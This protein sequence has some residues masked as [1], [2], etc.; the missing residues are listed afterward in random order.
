MRKEASKVM[1]HNYCS[2][3]PGGLTHVV[4]ATGI[5]LAI[6]L[7][8]TFPDGFSL[9][10]GGA[11]AAPTMVVTNGLKSAACEAQTVDTIVGKLGCAGTKEAQHRKTTTLRMGR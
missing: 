2:N 4:L 3:G 5:L 10:T 6:G 8:S 9:A 1:A 11:R 7:Y